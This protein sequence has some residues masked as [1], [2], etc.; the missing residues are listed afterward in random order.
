VCVCSIA[1][2]IIPEWV[3]GIKVSADAQTIYYPSYS[4]QKLVSCASALCLATNLATEKYS[5][6]MSG[7]DDANRLGMAYAAM[8]NDAG[9]TVY[10]SY[11][12]LLFNV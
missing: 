4:G 5:I 8:I 9:N 12:S 11:D 7:L 1:F 2:R 3:A 6:G 10:P